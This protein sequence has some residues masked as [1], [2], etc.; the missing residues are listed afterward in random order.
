MLSSNVE[1]LDE[2]IADDLIFVNQFGQIFSKQMDIEAH[3]SGNL[4]ITGIEV[5]DQRIRLNHNIDD[6][7]CSKFTNV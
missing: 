7:F 1:L 4:K 3:R 2:L 5:L 6:L